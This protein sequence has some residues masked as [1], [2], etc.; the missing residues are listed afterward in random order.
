[1][2]TLKSMALW[3]FRSCLNGNA[4]HGKHLA[5]KCFGSWL[6]DKTLIDKHLCFCFD[7]AEGM[8]NKI[9]ELD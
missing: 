4:M 5:I 9:S 3:N 6:H 1:M 2:V 8:G 7:V